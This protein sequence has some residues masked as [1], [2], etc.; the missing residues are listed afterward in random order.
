M[1]LNYKLQV[2]QVEITHL[3]INALKNQKW[4][5]TPLKKK[6]NNSK[7][8]YINFISRKKFNLYIFNNTD[9]KFE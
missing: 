2:Q 3:E 6:I 5:T 8:K 7:I 1:E 9:T 4:K